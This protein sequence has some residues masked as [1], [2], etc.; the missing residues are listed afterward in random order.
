MIR[1]ICPV[2]RV[3]LND[4]DGCMDENTAPRY[5]D[6]AGKVAVVTGGSRGIGAATARA[7]AA[8]GV[9]VLV[10]GRDRAALDATVAG[11]EGAGGTARGTV[12]DAT[13]PAALDAARREAEEALGPVDVLAAFVGEGTAR[14]GPLHELSVADWRSTVDGCL[15]VT[16]LALRCFLPGMVERRRGAIVTMSSISGRVPATGAPVPYSAAKAGV[17]MLTREVAAQYGP[18]GIRA[19]CVA[20]S[21]VLTERTEAHMPAEFRER[22]RALHPLGRLGVPEDVAHAAVFLASDAASWLTGLTVDVAGGRVG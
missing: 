17:E 3:G 5:P 8:T 6:L 16:F 21:T 1:K 7:L 13:D 20:P 18:Y 4:Q 9:K 11:I 15:T 19:N 22:V 14:P 2:R 12:A 10:T